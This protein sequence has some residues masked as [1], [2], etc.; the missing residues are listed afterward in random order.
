MNLVS[1]RRGNDCLQACVA[2][3]LCIDPDRL[4]TPPAAFTDRNW[5]DY[6]YQVHQVVRSFGFYLLTLKADE[7]CIP[8]GLAIASYPSPSGRDTVLHAVVVSE[9]RV[10]FDPHTEYRN[11]GVVYEGLPRDYMVFVAL[12]PGVFLKKEGEMNPTVGR[13]VHYTNLGDKDDRYPPEQQAAMIT[14]VNDDGTVALKVFYKRGQFDLDSVEYSEVYE[15]G[16]WTW[17]PRV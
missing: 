10:V 17:P 7:D 9:G 4:P 16:K 12:E 11:R 1:M 8:S 14:G 2:T 3:I 5:D 6:L 13:I 15:R